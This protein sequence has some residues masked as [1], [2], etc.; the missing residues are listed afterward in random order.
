M[1]TVY[2]VPLLRKVSGSL[3]SMKGSSFL[4]GSDSFYSKQ[5]QPIPIPAY[6]QLEPDDLI[7]L[8]SYERDS[9][10]RGS[11]CLAS[12]SQSSVATSSIIAWHIHIHVLDWG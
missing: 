1:L 4:D 3:K 7:A 11:S 10:G 6:L 2:G 5:F 12:G 9:D 8:T